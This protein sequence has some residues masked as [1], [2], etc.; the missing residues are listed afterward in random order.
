M[1]T[2]PTFRLSGIAV[3]TN[4]HSM[5]DEICEHFVELPDVRRSEGLCSSRA[6][7][8]QPRLSLLISDW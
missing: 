5:L 4:A 6:T 1:D 2:P 3:P 8:E 7:S